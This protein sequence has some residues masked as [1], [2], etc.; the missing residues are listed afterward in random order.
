MRT[1][2]LLA[3]SAVLLGGSL[4]VRDLR[5]ALL[6]IGVELLLAPAVLGVRRASSVRGRSARGSTAGATARRLAP[7]VLGVLSVAF[8]N[9]LLSPAHDVAAGVT[10]GLRVAFFVYRGCCSPPAS[11]RSSSATTS[12]SGCG[13]PR[14]RSSPRSRRCSG[15]RAW[16]SSGTNCRRTR[17][18]RG[19]DAGR[20]PLARARQVGALTAGLL[21][22][23]L[24]QAGRMAVAME[25]RGFSGP[26]AEGRRRTWAEAAPWRR[27]DSLMMAL[28]LAVAAVPALLW[29]AR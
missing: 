23:S 20:T 14:A 7:G 27:A 25:A 3:A 29:F 6:G 1:L 11:T 22:Q 26:R 21:V 17:R 15:S 2:S 16:T 28:G 19:L 10:A 24:R 18:V 12:A 8:S 13:C 5:T 4:F 9:W